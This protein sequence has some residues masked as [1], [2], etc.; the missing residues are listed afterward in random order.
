MKVVFL[1]IFFD[2]DLLSAATSSEKL[3]NK[4]KNSGGKESFVL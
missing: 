4:N 3:W 2:L 1:L